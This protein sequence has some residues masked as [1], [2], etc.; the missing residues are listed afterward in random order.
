MSADRIQTRETAPN[1][2]GVTAFPSGTFD[3][4]ESNALVS[5]LLDSPIQHSDITID[6][7][8]VD[9]IDSSGIGALV[10][11]HNQLPHE[12]RPIKLVNLPSTVFDTL[13]RFQLQKICDLERAS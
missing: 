6:F 10:L 2:Y 11:L 7:Q 9:F 8:N 12:S 1:H 13:K 3:Y 4:S 5:E